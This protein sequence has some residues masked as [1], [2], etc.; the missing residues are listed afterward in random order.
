MPFCRYRQRLSSISDIRLRYPTTTVTVS[1]IRHRQQLNLRL[2]GKPCGRRHLRFLHI[3]STTVRYCTELCLRYP[4]TI[5]CK[6]ALQP[7]LSHTTTSV[8]PNHHHRRCP[9]PSSST[10]SG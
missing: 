10:P 8:V 3:S 9:T 4:I 6:F 7:S 2:V 1:D 5:S